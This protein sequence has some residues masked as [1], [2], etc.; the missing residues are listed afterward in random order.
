MRVLVVARPGA[1]PQLLRLMLEQHGCDVINQPV[2]ADRF[3]LDLWPGGHHW[4]TRHLLHSVDVVVWLIDALPRRSQT[5]L[6][7]SLFFT[8]RSRVRWIHASPAGLYEDAGD[9]WIDESWRL[10]PVTS[11]AHAL[12]M[13]RAV[14]AVGRRR[15]VGVG[16]VLRLGRSYHRDDPWTRRMLATARNGWTP[17]NGPADAYVPTIA[18]EDAASAV[19]HAL[20][21]PHGA[22]NV[23]DQNPA[24]N[25][26]LNHILA[27]LTEHRRLQPLEPWLKGDARRL[28]A[29]SHRLDSTNFAEATQWRPKVAR[30]VWTGLQRLGNVRKVETLT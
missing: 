29:R 11:M 25:A 3:A 24:T 2:R 10:A 16:V 14:L 20:E 8:V 12:D 7:A 22:Y 5:R 17:F 21:V 6:F 28:T 1:L 26:E 30:T 23:C 4:P 15:S 27:R 13:E 18:A 9:R 19:V